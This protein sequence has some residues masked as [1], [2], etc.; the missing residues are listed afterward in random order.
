MT[1]TFAPIFAGID[2]AAAL[3]IRHAYLREHH[4]GP[5]G[6]HDSS[7]AEIMANTRIQGSQRSH[8]SRAF[9]SPRIGSRP[10]AAIA[11]DAG[12]S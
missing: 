12:L 7:D 2:N 5:G 3:V 9:R 6:V 4:D 1:L 10:R 11:V 8:L